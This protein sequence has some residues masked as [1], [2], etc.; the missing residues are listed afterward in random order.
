MADSKGDPN[1]DEI[2]ETQPLINNEPEVELTGCG[3]LAI[4]NPRRRLHRF[5]ILV[6]ICSLSFGKSLPRDESR[7][8]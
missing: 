5:V 2:S 8:T 7:E 4:C 3:N 1:S 6:F